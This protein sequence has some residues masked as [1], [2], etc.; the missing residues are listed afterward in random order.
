MAEAASLL[1]G[2][3]RGLVDQKGRVVAV[4]DVDEGGLLV[5]EVSVSL[6]TSLTFSRRSN[7]YGVR[8][9]TER[10]MQTLGILILLLDEDGISWVTT[11]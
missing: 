11:P 10:P 2:R 6:S 4:A 9:F 8:H 7:S 3:S 1:R 5:H